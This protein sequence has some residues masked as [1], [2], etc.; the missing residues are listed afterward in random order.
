MFVRNG[1]V[2]CSFVVQSSG[3]VVSFCSIAAVV[4][5]LQLL[6]LLYSCIFDGLLRATAEQRHKSKNRFCSFLSIDWLKL[7]K[8]RTT[9]SANAAFFG[10][11]K[12]KMSSPRLCL[13]STPGYANFLNI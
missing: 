10:K 12:K 6:F 2:V 3:F 5:L 13:K 11:K 8:K 4:V 1:S 9:V 7:E